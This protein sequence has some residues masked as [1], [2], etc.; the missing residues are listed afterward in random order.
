MMSA[1]KMASRGMTLA[2]IFMKT[3]T[4]VHAIL[5]FRLRYLRGCNI[6]ITDEVVL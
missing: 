6:G 5:R 2:P 4:G 3:G 1:S